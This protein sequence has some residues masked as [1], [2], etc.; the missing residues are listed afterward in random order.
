LAL[1]GTASA[2][3]G[4]G[5]GGYG[6]GYGHHGKMQGGMM[7]QQLDQETR[8]KIVQF[9][10]DNQSLRKEIVMKRAEKRATMSSTNADPAAAAKVAGELF[11]LRMA[12]REKAKAAGVEKYMGRFGKGGGMG[13]GS[14]MGR[15][16]GNCMQSGGRF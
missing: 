2:Q 13:S 5:G 16:H 7:F 14:M 10:D 15:G 4:K 9:R 11:D 12:M 1:V 6:G 8:D 3:S